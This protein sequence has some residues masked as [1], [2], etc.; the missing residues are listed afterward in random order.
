M[1]ISV[2][3]MAVS[4]LSGQYCISLNCLQLLKSSAL[5]NSAR[6]KE[7][8]YQRT[9]RKTG[10]SGVNVMRLGIKPSCP[11]PLVGSVK[12]PTTYAVVASLSFNSGFTRVEGTLNAALQDV[13]LCGKR[14]ENHIDLQTR[15]VVKCCRTN[16]TTSV[17]RLRTRSVKTT[18]RIS[19]A[20][21]C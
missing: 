16:M 17:D 20:V 1:I 6:Y 19:T 8:G 14:N 15:V 10:I 13:A 9:F 18:T 7:H 2:V 11:V 3:H 5:C 21:S 4:G 12:S